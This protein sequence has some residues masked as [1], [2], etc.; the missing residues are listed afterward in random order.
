MD[1]KSNKKTG[2]PAQRTKSTG[3]KT[4]P[5]KKTRSRVKKTGEVRTE[6]APSPDVKKTEVNPQ[7]GILLLV[8]AFASAVIA[9]M[10][11]S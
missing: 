3:G 10:V 2:R 11:S 7:F 5:P 8:V 4:N 9:A 1:S 6:S